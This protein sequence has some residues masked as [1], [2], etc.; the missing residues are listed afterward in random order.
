[1]GRD[2]A[3]VVGNW[4]HLWP[5]YG[6]PPEPDPAQVSTLARGA[7]LLQDCSLVEDRG[8]GNRAFEPHLRMWAP[9]CAYRGVDG[10]GKGG[11]DVVADL[12][13]YQA[14]DEPDGIY[15]RHVLEHNYGWRR[16]ISG[17]ANDFAR[18]LVLVL[19]TPPGGAERLYEWDTHADVPV[20]QGLGEDLYGILDGF[21]C[22]VRTERVLT[23]LRTGPET[24]LDVVHR[25]DESLLAE[26]DR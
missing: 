15:L 19:Y 12:R 16:V 22:V 17:A 13:D 20:L 24:V 5:E 25:G 4:N 6:P 26:G 10:S 23:G 1:M 18:R 8:C 14:P 11:A 3:D 7:V 21:G 9:T 2:P